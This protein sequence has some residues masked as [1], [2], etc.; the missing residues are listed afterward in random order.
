MEIAQIVG[1]ALVTTM[2]LLIL[3]QERPV[4]ALVLSIVFSVVIFTF[5]M[6]KIASIIDVMEE[7]TQGPDQLFLFGTLLKNTGSR[8]FGGICYFHLSGCRGAGSSQKG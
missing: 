8:L 7:L 3:R 1:I 4:M 2:L 6:G 5:L